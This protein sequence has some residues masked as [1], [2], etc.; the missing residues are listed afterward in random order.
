MPSGFQNNYYSYFASELTT[1]SVTENPEAYQMIFGNDDTYYWLASP[2][3]NQ[4]TY[5]AYFGMRSV[6]GYGH[7]GGCNLWGSYGGPGY[8]GFGVRAVVTL[9]SDIQFTEYTANGWSY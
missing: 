2:Y 5:Y 3:V 8:G 9:S 4:D 1:I 7:V 6:D